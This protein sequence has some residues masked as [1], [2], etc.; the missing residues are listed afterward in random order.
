MITVTDVDADIMKAIW[1]GWLAGECGDEYDWRAASQRMQQRGAGESDAVSAAVRFQALYNAMALSTPL[2]DLLVG[3]DAALNEV[4]DYV[5]WG[6]FDD[7]GVVCFDA[8]VLIL[9]A[10]P[11]DGL[12]N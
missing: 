2:I 11:T 7:D 5:A 12:P 8:Y 3:D 9:L 4:L 6:D 10:L 1:T